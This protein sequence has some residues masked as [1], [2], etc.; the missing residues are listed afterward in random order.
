MGWYNKKTRKKKSRKVS[1]FWHEI[2]YG[3]IIQRD[4]TH[5]FRVLNNPMHGTGWAWKVL[6]DEKNVKDYVS[7]FQSSRRSHMD[8]EIS[9][10]QKYI[11]IAWQEYLNY[12]WQFRNAITRSR[13]VWKKISCSLQTFFNMDFMSLRERSLMVWGDC[14]ETLCVRQH[15]HDWV[16]MFVLLI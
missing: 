15:N 6:W 4:D 16:S 3:Q 9:S 5:K 13:T 10:G 11:H 12:S 1:F 8:K 14:N 2:M 7:F